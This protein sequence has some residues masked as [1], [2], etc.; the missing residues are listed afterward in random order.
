MNTSSEKVENELASAEKI[1]YIIGPFRVQNELMCSFLEEQSGARCLTAE[2]LRA[3][4]GYEE[5]GEFLSRLILL[6]CLGKNP[7]DLL[8]ELVSISKKE[9]FSRDLI[10]L[11]NLSP[12]LRIEE[13][14]VMRGVRGFF[15]ARDPLD[16]FQKGIRAIFK[17]E[18][19]LSRQIMTR[20]ILENRS[21]RRLST[22]KSANLTRRE[23]EILHMIAEGTKNAEIATRLYISPH[24]VK[25]HLY[26]IYKKIKV[27][28]RLEAAFW[29]T[30]NL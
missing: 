16:R 13:E 29:A 27:S 26:N 15:Y 3:I 1:I 17:G 4:V 21:Q 25:T 6:D 7:E 24:T 8:V 2:N 12:G 30:D 28:N 23:S 11:F 20:F 10:A 22:T 5:K 14:A 19:W 18:L 9:I